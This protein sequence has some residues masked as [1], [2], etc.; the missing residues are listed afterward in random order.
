MPRILV[1][2]G[3][4]SDAA[5]QR[6]IAALMAN[7]NDV[8]VVSFRKK[9]CDFEVAK[10]HLDLGDIKDENLAAR[11]CK[12]VKSVF[13]MRRFVQQMPKLDVIYARNLD[14]ILMAWLCSLL[15]HHKP[16]LVYEVLDIHGIFIGDGF[17]QRLARA[18]ERFMLRRISRLVVSSPDFLDRYFRPLQGFHGDAQILENKLWLGPHSQE[19]PSAKPR[20]TRSIVKMGWVG[21]IRCAKSMNVLMRIAEDHEQTVEIHI[22]GHVHLHAIPAFH[23]QISARCNVIFHGAY[24]YPEDLKSIYADCDLVWAQDLWQRGQNSDWLLPN[25]LYEAAWRGCPCIALADTM[26]GR[27]IAAR[28]IGYVVGDL[29]HKLNALIA[30]LDVQSLYDKRLEILTLDPLQFQQTCEEVQSVVAFTHPKGQTLPDFIVIG[31]MRSG[32]TALY[33]LCDQHPEIGV[34]K[35][36]ETDFFI[37]QK[38]YAR[39]LSWYQGLFP[40]ACKLRGE[41]SPNY[42]KS[43]V[44][45]GVPKRMK[46]LLPDVKLIYITRNPV[47]RAASQYKHGVASGQDVPPPEDLI[48]SDEWGHIVDTS[49]YFHQIQEYME[50]FPRGQILI[51]D[52]H[53]LCTQPDLV[54]GDIAEFLGVT[55]RWPRVKRVGK[56]SSAG[57]SQVPPSVLRFANSAVFLRFKSL[58]PKGLK[59]RLRRGMGRGEPRRLPDFDATLRRAVWLDVQADIDKF[60]RVSG[61]RFDPPDCCDDIPFEGQGAG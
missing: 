46:D 1:L 49:R 25:R 54:L 34:S 27:Q 53:E 29:E 8:S 52:F 55:D 57:L 48:G 7:D 58:L 20:P 15:T 40:N 17:R 60:E 13:K 23:D 41:F 61:I 42:T 36:K 21:N 45:E 38:N 50:H 44:F 30:S 14:M 4:L 24:K 5:Q 59:K 31:S 6:R 51:L 37:R 22:H 3:D 12:L 33:D 11:A 32:T 16:H 26:T 43:G 2:A 9:S 39:G 56:N 19:R 18:A 47:D 35:V 10:Q 28:G